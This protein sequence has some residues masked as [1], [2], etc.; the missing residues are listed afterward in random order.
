MMK[1]LAF[2]LVAALLLDA[3]VVRMFLVP[4]VMKLLGG[5]CWWT[6]RWMKHI[7]NRMG[8]G[9]IHLPDERKGRPVYQSEKAF[10]GA[11]AP[12]S[13][14]PMAPRNFRHQGAGLPT[15]LSS[16]GMSTGAKTAARNIIDNGG[17]IA[18]RTSRPAP[19]GNRPA[20]G[21]PGRGPTA[22]P[23][24]SRPPAE[25]PWATPVPR[26]PGPEGVGS[27][28]GAGIIGAGDANPRPPTGPYR[29]TAITTPRRR[30]H[31]REDGDEDGR[32]RNSP[33]I[34][35]QELLRREGRI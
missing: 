35:V 28:T 20:P 7:Q 30:T 6:P 18:Q 13:A 21:R 8:L 23:P 26:E 32:Q 9:E 14:A 25:T 24:R 1:Y 19:Q 16:T 31:A 15:H 12:V 5:E 34:S 4:S 22:A 29:D 11:V 3:T 27:R 33:S 17:A 10:A 2:G